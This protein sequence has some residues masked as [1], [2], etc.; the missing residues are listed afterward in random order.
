MSFVSLSSSF[1]LSNLMRIDIPHQRFYFFGYEFWISEFSILFFS[2]MFH[3]VR[4]RGHGHLLGPCLL[5]LFL[6]ADDL[7]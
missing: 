6:P 5:R 3:D 2:M 4:R 7:Q 1:S